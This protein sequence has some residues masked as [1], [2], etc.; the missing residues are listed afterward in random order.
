MLA[1]E[2]DESQHPKPRNILSDTY[3]LWKGH[4]NNSQR[5]P[6]QE[7]GSDSKSTTK[8]KEDLYLNLKDAQDG[9]PDFEKQDVLGDGGLILSLI[10]AIHAAEQKQAES[11]AR[12]YAEYR[13]KLKDKFEKE[14]KDA[15]ARE[16][17]YVEEADSLEKVSTSYLL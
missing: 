16:L 9:K 17:M 5:F 10:E 4:E 6:N 15:R 12:I 1:A 14:L 7:D 3:F 2:D 8:Q 11:D 13:Q